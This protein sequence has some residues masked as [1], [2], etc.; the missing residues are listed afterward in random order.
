[1]TVLGLAHINLTCPA[2]REQEVLAFYRDLLGLVPV[3]KSVGRR[4][5]GGWFDLG[6]VELHISVD[7]VSIFEQR[8]NPRH[9]ALFVDALAAQEHGLR[10]AGVELLDHPRPPA[11]GRRCFVLDPAGNRLE[12]IEPAS[13]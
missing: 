8:A 6:G 7:P 11:S 10:E 5:A 13:R 12:L 2:E 4:T 9:I 1:M 3:A